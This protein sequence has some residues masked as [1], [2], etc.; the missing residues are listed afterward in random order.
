[1]S[2]RALALGHMFKDT[3]LYIEHLK[4]PYERTT[5]EQFF[6]RPLRPEYIFENNMFYL[7]N[8]YE[9]N[10][11]ID[12]LV[13]R[14]KKL[15]IKNKTILDI[16]S[17]DELNRDFTKEEK[18]K[19]FLL[20]ISSFF[21]QKELN[22]NKDIMKSGM[23]TME[24]NNIIDPVKILIME[25]VEYRYKYDPYWFKNNIEG[26]KENLFLKSQSKKIEFNRYKTNIL[27]EESIL[28][29]LD[30]NDNIRHLDDDKLLGK[31]IINGKYEFHRVSEKISFDRFKKIYL[32]DENGKIKKLDFDKIIKIPEIEP[33]IDFYNNKSF[34]THFAGIYGR[35]LN[36][37]YHTVCILKNFHVISK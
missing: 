6:R 4:T 26:K 20:L 19:F 17:L 33:L 16:N 11:K 25:A 29:D 15:K 5:T 27:Y 22:N 13:T 1:M 36:E 34:S 18:M 23:K 21:G 37:K 10:S 8:G 35:F 7:Q 14:L 30:F 9:K 2:L 31:K 12:L 24:A 3:P 28:D 32:K